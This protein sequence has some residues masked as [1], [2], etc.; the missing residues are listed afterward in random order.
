MAVALGTSGAPTVAGVFSLARRTAVLPVFPS[1]SLPGTLG[2][3]P[4]VGRGTTPSPREDES[5]SLSRSQPEKMLAAST[6][7]F[8]GVKVAAAKARTSTR[9]NATVRAGAYDAELIATAVR[10][11]PRGP[12]MPPSG[13]LPAAAA[14]RRSAIAC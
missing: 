9:V 14:P 2:W 7:S 5:P 12:E 3:P 4:R 13:P 6:S 8:T 11:G 10:W 1:S